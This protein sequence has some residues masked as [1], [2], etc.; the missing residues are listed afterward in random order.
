M[1]TECDR[2]PRVKATT[3]TK[4]EQQPLIE[5]MNIRM[6][7]MSYAF[8]R[9]LRAQNHSHLVFFSL[10]FFFLHGKWEV[11]KYNANT[12]WHKHVYLK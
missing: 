2:A 7:P 10:E 12:F 9:I 6:I 11:L 5:I 3:T 1:I 8:D 4:L